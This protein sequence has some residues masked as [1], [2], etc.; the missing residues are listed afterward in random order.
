M[1]T[2][3]GKIL[4]V[5]A[6]AVAVLA[7]PPVGV[8][9]A[10][11][12]ALISAGIAAA[13]LINSL[14][15]AGQIA[16]TNQARQAQETRVQLGEGPR[17]A[18]FG[19]AA[20]G[21]SL[22]DAFNYGGTYSTDYEVLVLALADHR[23]DALE[24]FY[25]ND[26]FVTYAGDGPVAGYN[27][28]LEI[29]W[30]DGQEEQ[31]PPAVLT[32]N[33]GWTANDRLRGVSYV[34]VA[35]KADDPKSEN[36]IWTSGRPQF[37]FV[38]RGLKLYD[39]RL[40]STV[41]GGSGPQRWDDPATRVWSENA[42]LCRYNYDRGVY[43]CDRVDDP[44]QLLIGRGLSEVE[45]PP[46]RI[47][48]AANLCDETVALAGGGSEKRY[49]CGGVIAADEEF[50]TVE[51]AFAAAEGGIVVQPE[52]GVA[53]EPGQA[54][55][56]VAYITDNDI[57]TGTK[58]T[59]SEFRSESDQ[60]WCNTVAPRYVEPTQKWADHGAPVRRVDA[61]VI[62]DKGPRDT[63][64]SLRLVTSGTQA[65]RI[66]EIRRRQGRLLKTGGLTLGPRF[67]E[68]EEGDWIVWTSARRTKGVSVTFRIES[69]ALGAEWRNTLQLR[70]MAASVYSWTVAD[71]ASDGATAT[72]QTPVTSPY[73]L[74][75]RGAYSIRYRSVPYPVTAGDTFLAI[76][77]FTGTLDDGRTIDFPADT[78]GGLAPGTLYAVLWPIA[79]STE[80]AGFVFSAGGGALPAGAALTRASAAM[81]YNAAGALVNVPA[82][83][84]RF[85][86][87]PKTLAYR[88]L[89]IEGAATN[90]ALRSSDVSNAAWGKTGLTAPSAGQLLETATN[91]AH[92]IAQNVTV[93]SGA[94]YTFSTIVAALGSG[95]TRYLMLRFATSTFGNNRNVVFDLSTGAFTGGTGVTGSAEDL[96]GGK[97]LVAITATATS[98]GSVG[99]AIFL[100]DAFT[101]ST[102]AYAGSASAGVNIS[103]VQIEEGAK[104]TSRID[105]AGATA[106]RAADV[107]TLDWGA[108]GVANGTTTLRY[109]FDDGSTQSVA[110]TISGGSSV[111]PTN[112]N[113]S[114]VRGVTTA[115]TGLGYL[116]VEGDDAGPY[117]ASRDWVM[118]DSRYTSSGG[119]YPS[120]PADPGRGGGGLISTL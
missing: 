47:F 95:P 84:A 15:L 57:I 26:Q 101:T 114:R 63:P 90:L 119:T 27:G 115:A 60:E 100:R 97:W 106:S 17:K 45:A 48:A 38:V 5:A 78:I 46:E 30:R 44:T 13:Q 50:G 1:S 103:G 93:A 53:V 3:I 81:R 36:P 58:V 67:A 21:G 71:Q 70:E 2:T 118:I 41:P 73:Y 87:S 24:G 91:E 75:P 7:A 64:V 31:S 10:G 11:T 105:T 80:A 18:I 65:Q 34:T 54:K 55:A 76:A 56:P 92:Q 98:S 74:P 86:F 43:A 102:A 20:T 112:L 79:A 49:R 29:Y 85:D 94:A 82:N 62:A 68:L 37:L 89:L 96:G 35:Y 8:I 23:C 19:K 109:T 83:G 6:I 32:A 16:D 39:P 108:L 113:R 107:L 110:A 25:V 42:E 12:A 33:G 4:T 40:D 51:E 120:D 59:F 28:Q 9:G 77:A 88:G 99:A 66:G 22:C 111:I 61:D 69:Y 117:M 72:Q 104:P 52:G 14:I 116:A